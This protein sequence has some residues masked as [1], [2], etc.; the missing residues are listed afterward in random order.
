M[1]WSIGVADPDKLRGEGAM[2]PAAIIVLALFPV[3]A[4]KPDLPCRPKGTSPCSS[5]VTLAFLLAVY[6]KPICG[7]KC[8]RQ[9][10]LYRIYDIGLKIQEKRKAELSFDVCKCTLQT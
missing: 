6:S 3:E 4:A 5:R 10:C 2:V 9:G 7:L 8:S 1:A